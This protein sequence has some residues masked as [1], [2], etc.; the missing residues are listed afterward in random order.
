MIFIVK[1]IKPKLIHSHTIKSNLATSI[2]AL[3]SDIPNV[4][5]FTGLGRLSKGNFLKKD[6]F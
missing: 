3:I 5:S 4:L 2:S 1:A 6:I